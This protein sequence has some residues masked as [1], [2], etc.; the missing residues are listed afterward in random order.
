MILDII[1]NIVFS[2]VIA[3]L[4]IYVIKLRIDKKRVSKVLENLAVDYMIVREELEKTVAAKE[5]KGVEQTE[6]FLKFISDSRDWAFNYIE[7]VQE[8]LKKFSD[9]AGPTLKY[10]NTYGQSVVTPHDEAI[11]KISEAYEELEKLLPADI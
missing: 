3:A 11:K 6:G 4:V 2:I 10:I 9:V 7:E 5:N 1:S 8:G